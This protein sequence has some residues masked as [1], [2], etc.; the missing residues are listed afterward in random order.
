MVFRQDAQVVDYPIVFPVSDGPGKATEFSAFFG[1]ADQFTIGCRP[2]DFFRFFGSQ[3][4]F[5]ADF[6]PVDIIQFVA[7]GDV[8]LWVNYLPIPDSLIFDS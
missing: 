3:R 8:F 6:A 4:G 5:S 7:Q 2:A 1:K